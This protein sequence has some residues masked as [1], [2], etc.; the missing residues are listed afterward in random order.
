MKVT[1][2]Q[3]I[4]GVEIKLK[5][6][7]LYHFPFTYMSAWAHAL[8]ESGHATIRNERLCKCGYVSVSLNMAKNMENFYTSVLVHAMHVHKRFQ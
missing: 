6:E 7:T 1:F 2:C 4:E 3:I 5:V 8:R